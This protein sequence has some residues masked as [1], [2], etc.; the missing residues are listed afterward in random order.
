MAKS[1]GGKIR[2]SLP[3]FNILWS[4]PM[5]LML[6]MCCVCTVY[7]QTQNDLFITREMNY[8]GSSGQKTWYP[9]CLQF[10]AQIE[11]KSRVQD[12]VISMWSD[13]ETPESFWLDEDDYSIIAVHSLEYCLFEAAIPCSLSPPSPLMEFVR[14]DEE[15]SPEV[16]T[17]ANEIQITVKPV[18]RA[19]RW[20]SRVPHSPLFRLGILEAM[21]KSASGMYGTTKL[22]SSSLN[23]DPA[24]N[25]LS[26]LWSGPDQLWIYESRDSNF[27]GVDPSV[28]S[29]YN[30]DDRKASLKAL[31]HL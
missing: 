10:I 25:I 23:R 6:M 21:T 2:A 26:I 29:S 19:V 16:G 20:I 18:I 7:H 1:E 4:W 11:Q 22:L 15:S 24:A 9:P 12:A 14:I 30:Q 3:Q 5:V 27:A 31:S 28:G 17:S 8:Q 13:Y